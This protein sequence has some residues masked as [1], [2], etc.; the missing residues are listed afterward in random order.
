MNV[1][2]RAEFWMLAL[3]DIQPENQINRA[4]HRHQNNSTN[5]TYVCT[6]ALER[7]RKLPMHPTAHLSFNSAV[8]VVVWADHY[9][10][11]LFILFIEENTQA[12]G[13]HSTLH[14]Y[15]SSTYFGE[16]PLHC[17]TRSPSQSVEVFTPHGREDSPS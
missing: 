17:S 1:F 8:V 5:L 6:W 16:T 7:D 10:I 9:L 4:T 12:C 13:K 2:V 14:I 3:I 15:T 11:I